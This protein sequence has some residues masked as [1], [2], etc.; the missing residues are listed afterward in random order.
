MRRS[1][2]VIFP[3]VMGLV[4]S[5]AACSSDDDSGSTGTAGGATTCAADTRKDIYTQ[6]LTKPAA[7]F[8]VTITDSAFTPSTAPAQAGQVQKGMNS[9]TVE[10]LDAAKQPVD[11]ADVKLDLWMPDH[12]HGT[13]RVPVVTAEGGGKY[14]ITEIWLPM[15]GLWRF[16]VTAKSNSAD[17]SAEFNFCLD[18]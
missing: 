10:V 6:G 12:A 1:L 2:F 17:K 18:G 5:T 15:A 3:M 7:D 8:E 9:I 11:G 13:A 14:K 16:T 4:G